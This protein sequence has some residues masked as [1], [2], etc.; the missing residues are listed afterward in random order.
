[1]AQEPIGDIEAGHEIAREACSDCH[2]VERDESISPI[3][4]A[5]PFQIVAE[6]LGMN[7]R[8]LVAW[9]TT[10]HPSMPNLMLESGE[11]KDVVAY[12]VSLETGK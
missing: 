5:T 8:A 4:G 6:T 11:L 9:M 10:S 12:I 1:M 7:E 2:A 3:R